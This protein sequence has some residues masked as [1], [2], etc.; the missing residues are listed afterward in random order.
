MKKAMFFVALASA[1]GFSAAEAAELNWKGDVRYRY[2]SQTKDDNVGT[3]EDH[4]RD[5]HRS[6]MRLGVYPWINDELS[7]GV[8]I[9]TG[10]LEPTSRNETFDDLFAA[11]GIYM[12][13][14]FI[15][16]HP[17]FFNG[18]VNLLLGKRDVAKTLIVEK[19]LVWDSDL[20]FEGLTLQYG[21]DGDGKEKNGFSAV[22]GYYLLDENSSVTTKE[23]DPYMIVLQASYKGEIS[24]L[25]Y[26]IGAGY[27]DMV[28]LANYSVASTT[29]SKP[30]DASFNAYDFNMV[31]FFGSL[32]G[33]LTE[34]LP[35]KMYGQY[36][37]NTADHDRFSAIDDKKR[38]AY[39]VGLQVGNAKSPGQW[40]LGAEYVSIEDYAVSD[41]T[42]SD[43]NNSSFTNL[44]GFKISAVYH[45]VQNMTIGMNYFNFKNKDDANATTADDRQHLVQ[46]DVVVKF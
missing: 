1:L 6:R 18:D 28:H 3:T 37:F 22:A 45:L 10:G 44:E 32:G 5:R 31:E 4:S 27:Y 16:Y 20:T 11:D 8:Q 38:D 33:D 24:D 25:G 46:A 43:R 19:D 30:L 21:K 23:Q 40:S 39:L 17:M 7:A 2:E 36:A 9:S 35:W 12:N 15:D 34:T 42:D 14:A 41:I 29:V 13:E 26:R